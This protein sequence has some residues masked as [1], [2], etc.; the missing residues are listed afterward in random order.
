MVLPMAMEPVL[1]AHSHSMAEN[2]CLGVVI[3]DADAI[4]RVDVVVGVAA[5]VVVS[6]VVGRGAFAGVHKI[7][8]TA[9]ANDVQMPTP[10]SATPYTV[11]HQCGVWAAASAQASMS[12]SALAPEM[13]A[14]SAHMAVSTTTVV[15]D[16]SDIAAG[17]RARNGIRTNAGVGVGGAAGV[18]GIILSASIVTNDGLD[19]GV[20]VITGAD[21][22][23]VVIRCAGVRDGSTIIHT[24]AGA[25]LATKAGPC[26]GVRGAPSSTKA[27]PSRSLASD[28]AATLFDAGVHVDTGAA[29]ATRRRP[30]LHRGSFGSFAHCTRTRVGKFSIGAG[31]TVVSRASASVGVGVCGEAARRHPRCHQ[32]AMPALASK[33]IISLSSSTA[34][35]LISARQQ[36]PR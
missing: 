8:D 30:G 27:A 4:G 12:N 13:P 16:Q 6:T 2:D 17:V 1:K 36:Y 21:V 31:V 32:R 9:N 33:T 15:S 34:P 5:S 3:Y 26:L 14:M 28:S 25:N 11:I 20:G 18:C 24:S 29:S 7:G 23:F 19:A 22:D 35:V 10:L